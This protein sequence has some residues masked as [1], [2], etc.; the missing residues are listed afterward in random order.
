[1]VPPTPPSPSLHPHREGKRRKLFQ[2]TPHHIQL[3]YLHHN[4]VQ[5]ESKTTFTARRTIIT[6]TPSTSFAKSATRTTFAIYTPISNMTTATTFTTVMAST[7]PP[8]HHQTKEMC[9]RVQGK[10]SPQ[11][12]PS[13][14]FSTTTT[15][16]YAAICT[17]F[18]SRDY[19]CPCGV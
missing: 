16:L 2:V 6:F 13:P 17:P 9:H 12:P 14:A 11:S 5:S 4:Q 7:L 1:V 8:T 3:H 15:H 10:F 18:C 19:P